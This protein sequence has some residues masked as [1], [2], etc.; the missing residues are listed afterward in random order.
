[1]AE[2]KKKDFKLP[3][4]LV[5]EFEKYAPSGKQTAIVEQLIADWV[6][7]QKFEADKKAM[8]RAY[9]KEK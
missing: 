9:A 5:V 7:K 3:K 6:T 1:M 8:A 4:E 2:K